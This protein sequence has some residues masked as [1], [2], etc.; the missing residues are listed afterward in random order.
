VAAHARRRVRQ[1]DGLT[2]VDPDLEEPAAR[3]KRDPAAVG[4]EERLVGLLGSAE[5]PQL[6]LVG[7][8]V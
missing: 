5:Q 7:R 1:A 4:R 8:R 2:A 6:G 3:I